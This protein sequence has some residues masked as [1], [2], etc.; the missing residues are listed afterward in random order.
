MP[1]DESHGQFVEFW[2]QFMEFKPCLTDG[3]GY[4]FFPDH[5]FATEFL[6]VGIHAQ[7]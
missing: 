4:L 5:S 6:P 7:A 1:G 2:S 3:Q